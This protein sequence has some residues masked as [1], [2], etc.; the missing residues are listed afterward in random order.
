MTVKELKTKLN[1][2]PE[3]L[4][5]FVDERQTDFRYGLVKTVKLDHISFYEDPEDEEFL[6]EN[7][8]VVILTEE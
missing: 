6:L 4:E 7:V 2:I 8:E 1:Q 3:H 5:V